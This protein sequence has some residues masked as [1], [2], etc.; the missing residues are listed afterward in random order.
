MLCQ[1]GQCTHQVSHNDDGAQAGSQN[2]EEVHEVIENI[3]HVQAGR[4][5]HQQ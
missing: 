1:G 5:R 4:G 3:Q 2:T